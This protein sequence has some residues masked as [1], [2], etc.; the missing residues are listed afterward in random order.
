MAAPKISTVRVD[1]GVK[2]HVKLFGDESTETKPL[3]IALHGAPGLYTSAEPEACFSHL[4]SLF[5]VLV[6]DGRGS[7][8]SDMTGPYTH[9]RWMKDIDYLRYSGPPPNVSPVTDLL[10]GNGLVP[11]NSC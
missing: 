5:R 6:F 1:D 3:L 2:L 4:S 7:G 9:K 10:T 8:A 11:I